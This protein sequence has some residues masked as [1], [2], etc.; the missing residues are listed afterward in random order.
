MKNFAAG[1]P[2]VVVILDGVVR[3]RTVRGGRWRVRYRVEKD[4]P[5]IA[6]ARRIKNT[7]E[8]PAVFSLTSGRHR[9]RNLN[10][11]LPLYA[12]RFGPKFLELDQEGITWARGWDTPAANA[13]RAQR[14][15]A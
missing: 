9:R 8:Q 7:P 4:Q 11:P 10:R 1:Q 15:L 6:E 5:E 14:A 13:L 2:V 3:A 12:Q